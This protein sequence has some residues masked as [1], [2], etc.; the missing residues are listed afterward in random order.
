M[1]G[2]PA[3]KI[4][5]AQVFD[6]IAAA[7]HQPRRGQLHVIRSAIMVAYEAYYE[8]APDVGSLPAVTLTDRQREALVHAYEVETAPMAALRGRLLDRVLVAR[9]PFCGIGESSTLDHYLP[10]EQHPQ[11][12]LLSGNLVPSCG[13]CN[14]RKGRLVVDESTYVRFFLHP[15]F[16]KIPD[17]QFLH[18]DVAPLSDA[19]GLIYRL[20]RP[21]GMTR[22]TFQ[23]LNTHFTRLWLADRYRLMSLEHLRDRYLAFARFYGAGENSRRLAGEL[24]QDAGDLTAE[25]GPNHWRAVLY[26]ALAAN[27]AFCDGGFEA[28]RQLR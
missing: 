18:V 6:D 14:T 9:C 13:P 19:L 20:A 4:D 24:I 28:L 22:R 11:F 7:K 1:R 10:K 23:H 21:N 15:Y 12:A 3:L 16:D 17:L 25:H 27:D 2:V 8:A 5:D 26:L